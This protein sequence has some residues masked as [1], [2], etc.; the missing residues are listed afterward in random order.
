[1]R[2]LAVTV[3]LAMLAA[4]QEPQPPKATFKSSV[5]VVPVDVSVIDRAGRP[6]PDLTAQDFA[7]AV[8]GKPRR[9]ASAEF[10]SIA[11]T[12]DPAPARAVEYSSNARSAGG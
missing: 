10:I 2:A 11:A 8:D 9:I 7:L 12:A 4:A 6:I 1:M 3:S 5:D